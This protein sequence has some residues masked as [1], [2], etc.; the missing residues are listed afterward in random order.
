M[1]YH[2]KCAIVILFACGLSRGA[3]AEGAPTLHTVIDPITACI[4]LEKRLPHD[5]SSIRKIGKLQQEKLESC[6][7]YVGGEPE[8]CEAHLFAFTGLNLTLLS[9]EK[10]I[11]VANVIIS[12]PKWNLLGEIRVGQQIEV[13]EKLYGVKIPRDV[14]PVGFAKAC[15]PLYVWHAAGRITNV[16]LICNAC[17]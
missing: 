15:T 16:S 12:S 10:K 9:L 6:D 4:Q 2:P 5:L 17:D 7:E 14:S 13:L 1:G 11:S 8:K 3:L